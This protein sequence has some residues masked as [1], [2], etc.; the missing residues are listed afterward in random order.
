M[1][2]VK[3]ITCFLF[4]VDLFKMSSIEET[5]VKKVSS[6]SRSEVKESREEIKESSITDS[7]HTVKMVNDNF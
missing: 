6:Q 3:I 7:G 2:G 1:S 4:Q 5:E